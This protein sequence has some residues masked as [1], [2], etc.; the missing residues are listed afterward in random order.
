LR[1]AIVEAVDRDSLRREVFGDTADTMNGLFG[2]GVSTARSNACS[3]A[4]A[5]DVEGAKAT[6]AQA[7][8]S[9]DVPT[10]HVDFY[11][12]PSGREA[13][14]AQAIVDDLRAAG[15]PAEP[16]PNTFESYGARLTDGSAEL[17]RF[18]WVGSYPAAEEYLE[19]LFSSTGSD[20]VFSLA[21]ADL[22][23]LLAKARSERDEPS[24]AALLMSA[25]DRVLA[26]DVVLP[27]VRYRTHLVAT[28]DVHDVVLAPN[29]SFDVSRISVTP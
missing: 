26:L 1:R 7:Y 24:R 14:I 6:V 15:I 19:P 27:L 13:K 17:F 29:G 10:V 21:D 22:D 9:G 28:T 11:D 20:N 18:G 8:P 16:R 4:C 23:A 12:E 25:E 3:S 2:P 5:Y